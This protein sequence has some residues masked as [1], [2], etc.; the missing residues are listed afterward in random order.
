MIKFLEIKC[1][2]SLKYSRRGTKKKVPPIHFPKVNIKHAVSL[3]MI[4]NDL[5]IT[6]TYVPSAG[7]PIMVGG[8][9]MMSSPPPITVTKTKVT[10]TKVTKTKVKGMATTKQ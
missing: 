9:I 1:Y 8:D 6:P 3:T 5:K 4:S 2:M 7:M 10:R